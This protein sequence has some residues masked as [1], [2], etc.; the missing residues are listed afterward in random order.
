[1]YPPHNANEK[2][3]GAFLP[4]PEVNGIPICACSPF[5][6]LYRSLHQIG[7]VLIMYQEHNI[8]ALVQLKQPL[9]QYPRFATACAS[10]MTIEDIHQDSVTHLS[11]ESLQLNLDRGLWRIGISERCNRHRP[12]IRRLCFS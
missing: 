12:G 10:Q 7:M 5:M 2:T 6:I 3:M 1:M 8:A 4:F 9:Q 11:L